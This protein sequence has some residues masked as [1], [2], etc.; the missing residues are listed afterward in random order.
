MIDNEARTKAKLIFDFVFIFIGLVAFVSFILAVGFYLTPGQ[1][2][3]LNIIS[4]VIVVLFIAQEILRWFFVRNKSEFIFE[5]WFELLMVVLLLLHLF[6]PDGIYAIASLFMPRVELKHISLFYIAIISIAIMFIFVIKSLRYN[7]LLSKIKLHPGAIFSLSFMIVILLGALAFSLPRATHPGHSIRFIDALFT[8]TSAVC[9]TG[10]STFDIATNLTTL[11]KLILILLI[12]IGGLGVMTLT[13]FF[14]IVFAG[15]LSVKVRVMLK[16]MLSQESVVEVWRLLYRIFSLTILIELIGA[17]ILYF[18]M[19]GNLF[20]F[21]KALF[22]ECGFHSVS[23]FCNAGF[24]LYSNGL[25]YQTVNANYAYLTTI[26]L[27]IVLGGLGFS[28]LVNFGVFF[29]FKSD[30][31]PFNL[32]FTLMSKLIVYSTIFLIVIGMLLFMLVENHDYSGGVN[33]FQRFFH[34][35]FLS[36]TARTAGFNTVPT[37]LLSYPAVMILIILMWIGASPGS[38]GGGIKNTTAAI[39]V[40]TLFNLIIGK[41]RVELGNREI[42]PYSIHHAFLV[43]IASLLILGA[44]S[45]ILVWL[46]PDKNPIDLIF[47]ATSAI[48]TVGLTRNITT[49]LGDGG[50]IVVTLLMYIGRIGVLTFFISLYK[51]QREPNYKL[52]KEQIIVG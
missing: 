21:D 35:L 22:Y 28:T 19:G 15:G 29:R 49:N 25:M 47:E 31:R 30:K 8:S 12:Q 37:E 6:F 13:T 9:V 18:S 32:K 3:I 41:E 11:G 5:R 38:T 48:S 52:P 26:M 34:S 20:S 39:T 10:L 23:A 1:L 42:H 50:K 4:D 17:F 45:T 43:V 16:D 44:G 27:L 2:D 40:L 24:S 33:F 14:A 46:E 36:I 7:H 51:A